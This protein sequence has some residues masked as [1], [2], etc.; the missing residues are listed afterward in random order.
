[1]VNHLVTVFRGIA[2]ALVLA[3]AAGF[4]RDCP[5]KLPSHLFEVTESLSLGAELR[6]FYVGMELGDGMPMSAQHKGEWDNA[7]LSGLRLSAL[8]SPW[9]DWSLTV[10]GEVR[11]KHP[12]WKD[13]PVPGLDGR[14]WQAYVE[15]NKKPW[16]V[17][18]GLQILNFGMS[19]ILDQRFLA[20]SAEYSADL[21]TVGAFGGA[22]LED[23]SRNASNCLWVRYTS[24]TTGWRTLSHEMENFVGGATFTW[25]GFRPWRFQSM[26]LYSRPSVN[27]QRS[28]AVVAWLGGP[29]VPKYVSLDIEPTFL[30]AN[31]ERI[32]GSLVGE[33]RITLPILSTP[34]VLR[35]AAATPLGYSD[36]HRYMP[37]YENLSWGFLKR[38]SL[39]EGHLFQGRL[40][41]DA[42]PWLRP[43]A[44]YVAQT[45]NF[46]EEQTSDELD[47]GVELNFNEVYWLVL[48]YVGLN[49]AGSLEASHGVYVE[50]RVVFGDGTF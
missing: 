50:A 10:E 2:L 18:A 47:A 34:P 12:G 6:A 20:L 13:N 25:K 49:L 23:M 39:Y 41:W 48:S 32:M 7:F 42:T 4:A 31:E 38:Y 9:T 21:F 44:R 26:Y 19:S 33:V 40:D 45:F 28:H 43:M 30:V 37:V 11:Y 35:L 3:P 36:E 1:M 27:L 24:A 29:L 16:D 17:T 15:Y 14:P 8:W 46:T 22:T 5:S